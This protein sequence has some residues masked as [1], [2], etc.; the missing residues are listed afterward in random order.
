M[1][2]TIFRKDVGY[3]L[4]FLFALING[5]LIYH[6]FYYLLLLPVILLVSYWFV[7]RLDIIFLL[8][9]FCTPLSFNFENLFSGGIGFYFP[10]EPLLL[11]FTLIFIIKLIKDKKLKAELSHLKHPLTI[12]II[13]HL[14]W[15]FLTSISSEMPLVSF[16]FLL[17]RTWFICP[18]F[19]YGALYFKKGPKAIKRF[20]AAYTI[21]MFIAT[22]YTLINHMTHGFSEEAGHWVMWPFFK[23]QTSYGAILAMTIPI[24]FWLYRNQKYMYAKLFYLFVI[25]TFLIGLYFSYT[26]AAWLTMFGGFLIYVLY[27][28]KIKIKWLLSLSIIPLI[29]ILINFN[30]IGY[31]LNKNDAEHTTE[32]FSERLESMSNVSTDAS[33]LE[34]LNRWNSAIQLFKE[35]P[36]LGWGPGTYAFVYAPFQDASDLTIIST[37]F[38]DGGNAHSEYLGPLS[39]QGILGLIFIIGIVFTFFYYSGKFYINSNHKQTKGITL[40]IIVSLAT[41]FAHGILNNYLDTDKASILVWGLM[42]LFICISSVSLVKKN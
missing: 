39:E 10:T 8:I 3:T 19:F 42:S 26:R 6:D 25:V 21:P 40:M 29:M 35:R 18:L 30:E 12:L 22:C 23:D 1:L 24:S 2:S 41:Y 28:F 11:L 36:I 16:K 15:I 9:V 5:I 13:L 32:N 4:I 31:L 14:G 7:F 33:N 38:G 34:R 17:A 20:I 27:Y 37:N